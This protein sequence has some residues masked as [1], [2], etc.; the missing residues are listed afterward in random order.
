MV[1]VSCADESGGGSGSESTGADT[2]PVGSEGSSGSPTGPG[3]SSSEGEEEEA[4]ASSEPGEGSSEAEESGSSACEIGST[5]SS[6]VVTIGDSYFAIT[7]VIT[8]V[9]VHARLNGSLDPQ[10]DYRRY[11]LGGTQMSNGDIPGMFDQAVAEDP[12]IDTVIMTGGGNDVLIGSAN[13]C[14]QDPPPSE[15]C[16]AALD[17]VFGAAE[18]LLAD[19]AAAGVQHVVYSFYPHLPPGF[20]PGAKNETLDYAAPIVQELCMN[21]PV[22]CHFVDIR[23]AFEGHPEYIL[24]DAIHPTDA[25]SQVIA[26]LIWATMDANCIAP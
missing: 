23:E 17:G 10:E 8:G 1:A 6:E 16:L 25:G 3:T 24:G 21:A 9:M 26:D 4:E 13:I 20:P 11:E 15:T 18:Q 22:D 2:E 12:N 19:M 14:L 7:T 5:P